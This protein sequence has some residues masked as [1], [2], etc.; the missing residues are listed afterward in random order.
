MGK[1]FPGSVLIH[2]RLANYFNSNYKPQES[3]RCQS[4]VLAPQTNTEAPD[5]LISQLL[6]EGYTLEKCKKAL[7][8]CQNDLEKSR[9]YLITGV[10]ES[11]PFPLPVNYLDCHLFYFIL[12]ICESFFDM[13]YSC[14]ICGKNM[15]VFSLKP[16]CCSDERCQHS[17]HKLGVGVSVLKEI[18]RDPLAADFIISLASYACYAPP[19]PPVFEPSPADAGIRFTA[20]F[21]D[22]LPP[23]SK[24]VSRCK[25]DTELFEYIGAD[26]F[27]ILRF[28]ILTNK[29]QFFTLQRRLQITLPNFSG[30][31][32]LASYVSPESELIFRSKKERYGVKWFWHG[33]RTERWYRILHTGLKDF[34]NTQYQLQAGPIYGNGIYMSDSFNYSFWYCMPA[35]NHYKNSK[36]NN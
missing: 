28:F 36:L 2:N 4:Y 22:K 34:G 17:Y 1:I 25:D 20:A 8:F 26:S 5:E 3:Y 27:K 12:E 11:N 6:S 15:G 29:A 19:N 10:I 21:F 23:M 16:C 18:K 14:C 13:S 9:D 33:S 31:Q 32:F 7:Q 30:V 35:A 24:I